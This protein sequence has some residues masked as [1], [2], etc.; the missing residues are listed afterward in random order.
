VAVCHHFSGTE[1]ALL[2]E[3]HITLQVKLTI[4]FI[5]SGHGVGIED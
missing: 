3:S 2:K 4:P 1:K 5:P